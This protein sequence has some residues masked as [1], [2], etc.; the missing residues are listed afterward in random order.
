M[1]WAIILINF[2]QQDRRIELE[3][4]MMYYFLRL[5]R[6]AMCGTRFFRQHPIFLRPVKQPLIMWGMIFWML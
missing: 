2:D 6:C 5:M 1:E 3:F 4:Q